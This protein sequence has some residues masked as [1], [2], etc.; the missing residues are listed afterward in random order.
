MCSTGHYS[1]A[2]WEV[3]CSTQNYNVLNWTLLECSTGI[4]NLLNLTLLGCSMGIQVLNRNLG[5][6][7]EVMCSMGIIMCSTGHYWGVQ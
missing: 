3:R 4:Y 6:Q 7:R 2:Q 1:G 5:A